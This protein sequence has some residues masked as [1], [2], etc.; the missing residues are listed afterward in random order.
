[1]NFTDESGG[2][3]SS[4]NVVVTVPA[5]Q[6]TASNCTG[7]EQHLHDALPHRSRSH[8]GHSLRIIRRKL[9]RDGDDT[10]R[11][12]QFVQPGGV[13]NYTT[14]HAHGDGNLGD[15]RS[16]RRCPGGSITG[17]STVTITGTGFFNAYT[18]AASELRGAGL[19][20]VR[21]GHQLELPGGGLLVQGSNVNVISDTSLTAVTPAV[22]APGNWYV[23]VDTFGGDST[24][25]DL[26]L[27]LRRPG[28]DHHR[29]EPV[30]RS[31]RN[32]Y[33][34]QRRQ[35]PDRVDGGVLPR[36]ERQS[37]WVRH[38][39]VDRLQQPHATT[40]TVTVPT[41]GLTANSQYFPVITLP[42][43]QG[44]SGP[45]DA[46]RRTTSRPTSSPTSRSTR[47]STSA[48]R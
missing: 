26:R 13:L 36:P 30:E 15:R 34:H 33:H 25:T 45:D 39:C 41:T 40:M 18:A 38:Q 19:V 22:T 48:S 4:N 43:I 29:S 10:R 47:P 3:P 24:Q 12:S 37:D 32:Q 5:S 42:T 31:G 28:P 11:D 20:L 35:L 6:V 1:M 21:Y 7:G 23:Q 16:A 14:V 46:P 44:Y 2:T 27:Q 17:G 9:L 8:V